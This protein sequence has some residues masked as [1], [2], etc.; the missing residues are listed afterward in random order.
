M[1][2]IM[3]AYRSRFGSNSVL[4][5]KWE[6]EEL[7]AQDHIDYVGLQTIARGWNHT[8][9][10]ADMLTHKHLPPDINLNYA[11]R[12]RQTF[13][14]GSID[15]CTTVSRIRN[16]MQAAEQQPNRQQTRSFSR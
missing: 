11:I 14:A 7:I 10:Y 6:L 8:I 15:Y 5:Q 12:T 3:V 4:A 1:V 16:A 9:E 13:K 2:G